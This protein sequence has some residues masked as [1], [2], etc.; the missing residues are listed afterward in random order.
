MLDGQKVRYIGH[1]DSCTS[2]AQARKVVN[3]DGL[4]DQDLFGRGPSYEPW[5]ERLGEVGNIVGQMLVHPTRTGT[6]FV[7]FD[8]DAVGQVVLVYLSHLEIFRKGGVQ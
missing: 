2:C 7:H 3:P 5:E 4:D 8:G 1:T 6:T